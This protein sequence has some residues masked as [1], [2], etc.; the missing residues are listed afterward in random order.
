[1]RYDP[2]ADALDTSRNG[3]RKAMRRPT[4]P[5]TKVPTRLFFAFAGSKVKAP[6][7]YAFNHRGDFVSLKREA[8]RQAARRAA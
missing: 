2:Y 1:V 5:R 7:G 4:T 3:T 6:A 8:R